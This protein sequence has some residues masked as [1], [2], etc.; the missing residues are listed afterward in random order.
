VWTWR[1]TSARFSPATTSV[2]VKAAM[3][4]MIKDAIKIR[5]IEMNY[6]QAIKYFD[7]RCAPIPPT[8]L[9]FWS[10][11]SSCC[12]KLN[13]RVPLG[14]KA[15]VWEIEVRFLSCSMQQS[16]EQS[17]GVGQPRPVTL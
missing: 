7:S 5:P 12:N 9:S 13:K 2:Q 16:T 3:D 14:G 6:V 10:V 8:P 15:L 4:V 17:T 11:I 1:S